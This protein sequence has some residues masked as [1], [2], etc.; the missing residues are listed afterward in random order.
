MNKVKRLLVVGG[1]N[2]GYI[3]ALIL[4]TRFPKLQVDLVYSKKIPIMG[5][6]EASTAHIKDFIDFV[7]ID[8][9]ELIAESNATFKTYIHFI[10]WTKN[11]DDFVATHDS[12]H[13][14]EYQSHLIV[15]LYK[16]S[17]N[18]PIL[19]KIYRF[20]LKGQLEKKKLFEK[21]LSVNQLH[22]DTYKLNAFLEKQC[23][24]RNINIL[25][26]EILNVDLQVDGSINRVVGEKYNYNYDFYIDV[27]GTKRTIIGPMGSQWKEF[28]PYIKVNSAFVFR[29]K[30]MVNI[31]MGTTITAMN[32]GWMFRVPVIGHTGN[33][34]VYDDRY[35]SDE[36]AQQEV[37]NSI[38]H[39]VTNGR[40]I[41]FKP[42]YSDKSWI[43]NCCSIGLSSIFMDPLGATSLGTTIQTAFLFSEQLM[44]Y[45]ENSIDVYNQTINKM[46]IEIRD[47]VILH[48]LNGKNDTIFWKDYNTMKLPESL[49]R[50][51]KK[52]NNRLP[53]RK[54]F[55]MLKYPV[56]YPHWP[57][58]LLYQF[59]KIDVNC[60]R[61]I[62]NN[63]PKN[64]KQ[65]IEKNYNLYDNYRFK[66]T[67]THR[68]SLDFIRTS[69]AL[70]KR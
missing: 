55:T 9:Y 14:Q 10:K 29:T 11:S 53:M 67:V 36:E 20:F 31:D 37:E 70:E 33:G 48:Y 21:S 30:E 26:D 28:D 25:D 18:L 69:V 13:S 24:N 27:S 52:W 22:F 63:L 41:K 16:I 32:Y 56:V 3:S 1:G 38:K 62:Y 46:Y 61:N 49:Q 59:E 64:V 66:D 34:Y 7:G 35:V 15:W 19:S 58:V 12:V 2:A 39:K 5:V 43:K 17:K 4:K 60:I 65:E 6:G 57:I 45:D 8:Q 42:G 50:N 54:D 47:Y 51:L 23:L 40:I 68:Q 44:D